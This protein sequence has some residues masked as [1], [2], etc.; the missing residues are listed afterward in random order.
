M[1]S[2][3]RDMAAAK[4][5]FQFAKTVTDITPD[6]VTTGG[7]YSYPRAIRTTL[8]EAVK[9]LS[10]QLTGAGSPRGIPRATAPP[11]HAIARDL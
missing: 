10:Q 3:H 5:F 6:R 9:P 11:Q 8:D 1:F 7:H 2:E 4:A